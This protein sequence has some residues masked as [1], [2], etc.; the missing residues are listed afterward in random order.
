MPQ[1]REVVFGSG[2]D[3]REYS[4]PAVLLPP[5]PLHRL[6]RHRR[7][8]ALRGGVRGRRYGPARTCVR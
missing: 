7:H 8:R 5:P 2:A 3:A 6:Q 4:T 1:R